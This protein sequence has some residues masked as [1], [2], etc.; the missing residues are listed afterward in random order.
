MSSKGRPRMAEKE[1]VRFDSPG[2]PEGSERVGETTLDADGG[3]ATPLYPPGN[4][5]LVWTSVRL[6]DASGFSIER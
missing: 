4:D 6:R 3:G 1:R 2:E 5:W